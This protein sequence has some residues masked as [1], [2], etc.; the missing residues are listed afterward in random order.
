MRSLNYLCLILCFLL[1]GCSKNSSQA[2]KWSLIPSTKSAAPVANPKATP[3]SNLITAVKINDQNFTLADLQPGLVEAAGG[4]ILNEKILS[5]QLRKE[6]G[7]TLITQNQIKIERDRFTQSLHNDPQTAEKL[8]RQL[9]QRQGRGEIR[10]NDFLFRQAALRH[11][12]QPQVNVTDTAIQ[13]AY[14]LKFGEKS[15]VQIITIDS[16]SQAVAILN[17]ARKGE[18]FSELVQLFSLDL[19]SKPA[20][21]ILDPISPADA[22][23]P[24]A[25][26]K[27]IARLSVGQISD[28]VALDNGFVILKLIS[29]NA[30]QSVAL[31][32]VKESLRVQVQS[33]VEQMLMRQ[34]AMSL[35]EKA[36]VTVMDRKLNQSWQANKKNLSVEIK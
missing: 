36:K 25:V 2:T 9:C 8:L 20:N 19:A 6:L 26:H 29:K 28:V 4:Q 17:R 18:S 31:D 7:K 34:L 21:G 22:S 11:I 23:Y 33:E 27:A 5:L 32:D 13:Q 1:V 10:L 14:E 35:M 30:R 24:T 3:P 15:V 12:V 16:T